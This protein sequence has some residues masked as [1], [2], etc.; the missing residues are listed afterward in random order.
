MWRTQLLLETRGAELRRAKDAAEEASSARSRFLAN[1]SHEVRTPLNGVLGLAEL[2][3]DTTLSSEQRGLLDALQRSGDH[4]LAI[5]DDILD[6][7]K[8]GAGK[9]TLE[10]VPFDLVH[11]IRDVSKPVEAL[12]E[13]KQLRW[14]VEC[15]PDLC[16][17]VKGDPVRL[18]QVLGNLLG[19]AV[20][21]T[22]AGEIRLH[23]DHVRAG[24]VRFTIIDSGIGISPEDSKK[25]FQEF[26]Q[27]DSSTTRLFGGTGLGLAISKRLADLMGGD[28]SV[29]SES[30]T[31]SRFVLEIPLPA[32]DE[33]ITARGAREVAVA[34]RLPP[35]C[36]ILVAEDNPINRMITERFLVGTGAAVDVV[37]DGRAA[38][39]LHSARPYDLILMDC[40]MPEMDGYE[41]TAA[42]RSL[43]NGAAAVPIIA[44]TASAL[45]EDRDRCL[46]AGMDGHLSK[47]LRRNDLL[48]AIALALE[49]A[50]ATRVAC[51]VP[52]RRAMRLDPV[53][54][55]RAD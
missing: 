37:Q 31:G 48:Q 18:R 47:P 22:G 5:V 11:F 14:T 23:I 4:L 49:D 21:F 52:A 6:F 26:S 2:L 12:A 9:L 46:K 45:A 1:M 40:H 44:V 7:S 35:N 17:I 39:A 30:G 25:L 32:S 19:N 3:H 54:A 8:I 13:V 41:A 28:L 38:V 16:R 55:L 51:L 20:K 27:A 50:A 15:A 33:A 29:E 43:D 34:L 36:R 42:I 53:A 10:N 24:W